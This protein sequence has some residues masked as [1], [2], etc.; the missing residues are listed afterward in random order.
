MRK[1]YLIVV[2]RQPSR[3]TNRVGKW[4]HEIGMFFL[5]CAY[6]ALVA[7]FALC[8]VGVMVVAFVVTVLVDLY[9]QCVGKEARSTA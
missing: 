5:V 6:L 9:H 2:P 7:L 1:L 4:L 8:I 3:P